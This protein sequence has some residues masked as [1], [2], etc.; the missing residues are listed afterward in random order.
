M[1]G[2]KIKFFFDM[3]NNFKIY[4]LYTHDFPA[5]YANVVKAI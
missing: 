3:C 5:L 4:F 2:A 1:N